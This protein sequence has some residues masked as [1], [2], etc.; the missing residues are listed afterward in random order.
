M[1]IFFLGGLSFSKVIRPGEGRSLWACGRGSWSDLLII[2]AP[3]ATIFFE[4]KKCVFRGPPGLMGNDKHRFWTQLT[5]ISQMVK[6][7]SP[8]IRSSRFSIF[9][10]KPEVGYYDL[11]SRVIMV[12]SKLF[13][14]RNILILTYQYAGSIELKKLR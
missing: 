5:K 13:G 14:F 8:S 6:F 11:Y 10:I 9:P 1:W 12:Y 3:Q 4:I 2:G 7:E